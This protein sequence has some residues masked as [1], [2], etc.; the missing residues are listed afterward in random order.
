MFSTQQV[1]KAHGRDKDFFKDTCKWQYQGL[2]LSFPILL[3]LLWYF[4]HG[5]HKHSH[6]NSLLW[7][8]YK[9][10]IKKNVFTC[11]NEYY[12]RNQLKY[13]ESAFNQQKV[14]QQIFFICLESI[15]LNKKLFVISFPLTWN[16]N[17][18]QSA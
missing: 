12:A 4:A 7:L 10:K 6:D 3:S 2:H 13:I 1:P 5:K 18:Q 14:L 17:K 9:V 16:Q 11:F 8:K 15:I